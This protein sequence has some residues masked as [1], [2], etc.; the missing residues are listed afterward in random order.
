[1]RA[2]DPSL[3]IIQNSGFA[4]ISA[5]PEDWDTEYNGPVISIK[6]MR[7]WRK[8]PDFINEHGS[9]HTDAIVTD[10]Y[11]RGERLPAGSGLQPPS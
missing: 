8:R 7:A 6:V 11:T 4:A 5:S 9:H 3:D 10:S 2:D 1:M